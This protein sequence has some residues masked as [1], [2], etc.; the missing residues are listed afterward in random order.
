MIAPE[1]KHGLRNCVRQLR[2]RLDSVADLIELDSRA[3]KHNWFAAPRL[4]AGL[5][6]DLWHELADIDLMIERLER[7]Q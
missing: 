4:S 7:L 1:R 2:C 5:V 6:D 3:S